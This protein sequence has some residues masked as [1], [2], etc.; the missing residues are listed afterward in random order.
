MTGN[1]EPSGQVGCIRR[2]HE[3]NLILIYIRTSLT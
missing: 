2:S 1:H 3:T